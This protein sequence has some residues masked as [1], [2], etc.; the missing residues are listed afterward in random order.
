MSGDVLAAVPLEVLLAE[1]FRRV[2]MFSIDGGC[3]SFSTSDEGHV[4]E[5][6]SAVL[7]APVS[8]DTSDLERRREY[9]RRSKAAQRA[10]RRAECPE[11]MSATRAVVV[12]SSSCKNNNNKTGDVSADRDMLPGLED[13]GP[14]PDPAPAP[15]DDLVRRKL[16]TATAELLARRELDRQR[17]AGTAI[18]NEPGWLR[19]VAATIAVDQATQISAAIETALARWPNPDAAHVAR[20]LLAPTPTRR[21][22]QPIDRTPPAPRHETLAGLEQIRNALRR[23]SA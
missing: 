12:G 18:H 17:T 8:A 1:V 15:P 10:R 20:L 4:R 2:G 23:A 13:I 14:A 5:P 3:S 11:D 6:G 22:E 7:S 21:V 9:W 19:K 16:R